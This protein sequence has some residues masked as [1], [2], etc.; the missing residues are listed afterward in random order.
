MTIEMN[1]QNLTLVLDKHKRSRGH[2]E[3]YC[4]FFIIGC[5]YCIKST[6]HR[7]FYKKGK[8]GRKY[9]KRAKSKYKG[10]DVDMYMSLITLA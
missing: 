8:R 1:F 2:I 5:W 3:T 4:F 6:A 10:R 7:C 9:K